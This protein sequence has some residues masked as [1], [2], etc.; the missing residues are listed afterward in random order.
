[1]GR[2]VDA[3]RSMTPQRLINSA[4]ALFRKLQ[5]TFVRRPTY[6]DHQ[7][8]WVFDCAVTAWHLVDWFAK[9]KGL[10]L[11]STRARLKTMCSEL[12]VCEQICNGAK[13]LV[14]DDPKLK[15][16]DVTRDVKGTDHL[17]GIQRNVSASDLPVDI[18]LTPVVSVSDKDGKSW[19]AIE[20]FHAVMRFWQVE[21]G[22][23]D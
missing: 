19:D 13:H 2:K 18:V 4:E 23:Q 16:F 5:R 6:G 17:S 14:L 21:L 20:L 11:G 7:V 15:P 8:D 9:E 22:L 3:G 1:M 10:D 12:G